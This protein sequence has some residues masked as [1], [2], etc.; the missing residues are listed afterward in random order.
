PAPFS[1]MSAWTVPGRIVMSTSRFATT[2]GNRLVMPRTV[3]PRGRSRWSFPVRTDVVMTL[4]LGG[5]SV[6]VSAAR[7]GSG[8]GRHL[9]LA[10]LDVRG[11][12]V[13]LVGDV[14]DEPT[15]GGVAD[16]VDLQVVGLVAGQRLAVGHRL[17][18]VV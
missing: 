4:L 14:V 6:R 10:R 16:P 13:E 3:T 15:G 2:P 12:S 8:G 11:V 18:H 1:P 17:D 9:D 5:P 7:C